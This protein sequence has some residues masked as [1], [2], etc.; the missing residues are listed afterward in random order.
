MAT[1]NEIASMAYK[2]APG[3]DISAYKNNLQ[4]FNIITAMDGKRSVSTIAKENFYEVSELADKVKQLV[5]EG[6]LVPAHGG[7]GGTGSAKGVD[8]VFFQ[9]MQTEL[10]KLLGPVAGMLIKD[11]VRKMGHD[12]GTFPSGKCEELIETLAKYIQNAGKASTFKQIM[13]AKL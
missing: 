3:R 12:I 2:V 13:A 9:T 11:T 6:V 8:P 5:D 4:M 10:T 7:G 1:V